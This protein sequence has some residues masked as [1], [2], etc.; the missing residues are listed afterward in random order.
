MTIEIRFVIIIHEHYMRE[1]ISIISPQKTFKCH[2][3]LNQT[4]QIQCNISFEV[5]LEIISKIVFYHGYNE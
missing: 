3:S 4:A 5:D 1:Y 2:V